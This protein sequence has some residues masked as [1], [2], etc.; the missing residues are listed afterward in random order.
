M[1]EVVLEQLAESFEDL[2]GLGIIRFGFA[3]LNV[4]LENLPFE[5]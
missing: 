2:L 1:S 5:S 4:I 3:P